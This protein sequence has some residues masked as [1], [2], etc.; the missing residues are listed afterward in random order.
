M[1][2]ILVERFVFWVM[3]CTL[4]DS[5]VFLGDVLYFG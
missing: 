3:S 1:S 4:G 5:L 2:I